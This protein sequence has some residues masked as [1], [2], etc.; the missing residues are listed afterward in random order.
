MALQ[1][2]ERL[3]KRKSTEATDRRSTRVF[4]APE[5]TT[6]RAATSS[7]G[8]PKYGDAHP[9]DATLRVFELRPRQV[10]GQASLYEVEVA[11]K[12]FPIPGFD[13]EP[14]ETDI[15]FT[16]IA[17]STTAVF[18]DVYRADVDGNRL[19]LP[20]DPQSPSE[21][22]DI[23]G[24]KVDAAGEPVSVRW[25]DQSVTLIH[26]RA[27]LIAGTVLQDLV[28]TRNSSPFAGADAGKLVFTG[29]VSTGR[30]GQNKYRVQYKFAYDRYLHL[31]QQARRDTNGE[32]ITQAA[33]SGATERAFIVIWI[34]PFAL[35]SDFS[36][37]G[38]PL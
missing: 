4:A 36:I 32:I 15:G 25:V 2:I 30:L 8:M 29:E 11:Y 14:D 28:N 12:V 6:L 34:Q 17:R 23:G 31:V 1:A 20:A 33:S 22:I 35:L 9:E 13:D 10:A 18:K 37:L 3:D 24:Q 7:P 26:V 38:I 27:N 19:I 21:L 16:D 5:A